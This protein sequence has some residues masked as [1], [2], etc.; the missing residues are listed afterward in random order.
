M[1]HYSC[2]L[3]LFLPG[4]ALPFKLALII[5]FVKNASR[6]LDPAHKSS[7]SVYTSCCPYPGL[8]YIAFLCD[9]YQPSGTN[10]STS[11]ISFGIFTSGPSPDN[12]DL[13]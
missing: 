1:E 4:S 2:S 9:S 6:T 13:F 5:K 12:S 3:L 7:G 8:H 10:L 11:S